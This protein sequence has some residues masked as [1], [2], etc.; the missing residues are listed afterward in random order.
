[1]YRLQ[2]ATEHVGVPTSVGDR[3]RWRTD[4][5]RRPRTPKCRLQSATEHVGAS[6]SVGDR[7]RWCTD[8]IRRPSTLAYRR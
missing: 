4:F 7:A 1:M 6:P 5:S 8:F 3:A 2:S